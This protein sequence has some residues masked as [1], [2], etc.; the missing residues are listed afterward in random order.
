MLKVIN[1]G[2]IRRYKENIPSRVNRDLEFLRPLNIRP[3]NKRL[4]KYLNFVFKGS[5]FIE[6]KRENRFVRDLVGDKYEELESKRIASNNKGKI[7][8]KRKSKSKSERKSKKKIGQER[9]VKLK[10]NSVKRKGYKRI[11]RK[12]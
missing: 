11:K 7:S 8:Q 6:P 9:I 5:E 10:C 3:L 1:R 4:E 2:G 12:S